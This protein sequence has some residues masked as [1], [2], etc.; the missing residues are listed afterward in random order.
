MSFPKGRCLRETTVE[1][2]LL[3]LLFLPGQYADS[4]LRSGI[5]QAARKPLAA[6]VQHFGN[7]GFLRVIFHS[8]DGAGEDPRVSIEHWP[9]STFFEKYLLHGKVTVPQLPR[10]TRLR[11]RPFERGLLGGD[12]SERSRWASAL[13]E[14]SRSYVCALQPRPLG[15]LSTPRDL[16]V[17]VAKIGS[18]ALELS[19]WPRISSI[20]VRARFCLL[21]EFRCCLRR[22]VRVPD[23]ETLK[24][25][26]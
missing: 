12:S 21:G 5:V 11:L 4:Y 18:E 24:P 10:G 3:D 6:I 19:A 1:K 2:K 22:A 13:T 14:P 7:T 26:G 16:P 15:A 17:P 8:L 9:L 23:D 25:R 20:D